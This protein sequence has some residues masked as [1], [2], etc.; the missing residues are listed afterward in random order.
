ME[1]RRIAVEDRE[2]TVRIGGPSSRHTVLLLP[3]AGDPVDVYDRVCERLHTSDLRTI[4]I[5]ALDDLD[6]E[7]VHA[8]LDELGVPWAN[9]AGVGAGADLA[10]QLGA[11]GFGRFIGLVVAGRAHPAAP[12]TDGAAPDPSCPPVE[13]PTTVIGTKR[14]PRAA[15][16][17][18]ARHVFGEFR[19]T[20]V[21]VD[22]VAAEAG[23]ELATEIVLRSGLW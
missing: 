1:S 10:W 6:R 22:H 5:E 8:I 4:V 12:G 15:A 2:W 23:Q 3:D 14:L 17:A 20:Q 13:L 11:R 9:L 21:D 18:S 7:G 19:V 16:E